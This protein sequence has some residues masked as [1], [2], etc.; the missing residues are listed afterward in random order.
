MLKIFLSHNPEDL[1]VYFKKA[2]EALKE[3]G[4]V[5]HNPKECDLDTHELIE[6]AQ[7]CQIVICHRATHGKA[8]IFENLPDLAVFLPPQ[9]D[10][11]D[12]VSRG[13]LVDE[14][15]LEA[16]IKEK[17]IAKVAMDVGRAADQRP[18]PHLATLP[19]V[20]ATP[21]LGGLTVQNAEDQAWSTV[22]QVE[23]LLKGEMVPRSINPDSA[24]RLSRLWAELKIDQG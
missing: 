11:S 14:A 13:N 3:F 1:E 7:G 16:A 24:E 18:S 10:I 20:V 8:A 2:H 17:H 5:V 22:E 6:A 12:N 9:V 19:G 15:A 23:A 21:H 4:E